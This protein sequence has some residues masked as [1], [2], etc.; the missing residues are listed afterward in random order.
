MEL[1]RSYELIERWVG[2]PVLIQTLVGSDPSGDEIELLIYNPERTWTG[3]V[4]A[5]ARVREL[6]AYDS[7]GVVLRKL[8]PDAPRRFVPWSAVLGLKGADPD[9]ERPGVLR[10][11]PV[12]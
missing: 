1:E 8:R 5:G 6:V 3:K 12:L 7:F 11:A 4:Q 9:A 10:G 2:Q